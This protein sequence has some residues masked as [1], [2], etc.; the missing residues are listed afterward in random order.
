MLEHNIATQLR[1]QKHQIEQ[2]FSG[3]MFRQQLSSK[4]VFLLSFAVVF[5]WFDFEQGL[6]LA[7][8]SLELIL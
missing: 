1:E 4:C 2:D 6:T 5:V 7:S 3:S 8:V